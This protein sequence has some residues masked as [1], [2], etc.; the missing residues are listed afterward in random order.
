MTTQI[1]EPNRRGF[2]WKINVA[3]QLVKGPPQEALE[4]GEGVERAITSSTISNSLKNA[5]ENEK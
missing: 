5:E 3:W 4:L 1:L 2:Q